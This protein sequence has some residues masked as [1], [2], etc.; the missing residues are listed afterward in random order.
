MLGGI[1][2]IEALPNLLTLLTIVGGHRTHV[3]QFITHGDNLDVTT[4][5]CQM[6][7]SGLLTNL[8]TIYMTHALHLV[9]RLGIHQ[10]GH[11][12]AKLGTNVGYL[13]GEGWEL[14]RRTKIVSLN[15]AGPFTISGAGDKVAICADTNCTVVLDGLSLTNTVTGL[16]PFD[17][18]TNSVSMSLSGTNS[19]VS[20]GENAP[21]LGVRKGGAL[22]IT[23]GDGSLSALGG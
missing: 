5:R 11:T 1:F 3:R 18:G 15:G 6:V 21:G 16:P 22:E 2:L 13:S 19:L 20:C 9:V 23:G 17:C 14:D 10:T 7:D 4:G 8:P 12:V